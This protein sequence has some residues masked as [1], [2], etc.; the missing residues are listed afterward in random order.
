MFVRAYLRASTE[1]QNASRAKEQLVTFASERKHKVAACY[2]ENISGASLDRPELQRLL[3]DSGE[4]DVL[5][6][7]QVDRLT[8]L[9][10]SDWMR[11]KRAIDDKGVSIVALDLPTSYAAL[12]V[13][14]ESDFMR[15]ML[16]A[17]NNMLLDMLAAVARKDF[18]DRRR[19]QKQ[20]IIRAKEEGRYTGRRADTGKHEAVLKLRD[21]G[22]TLKG[23]AE[24]TGYSKATVCRVIKSAK[25]EV[26]I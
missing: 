22:H 6:L 17:I 7:E 3:D 19:R 16:K 5:L 20:G 15:S 4:G 18:E 21:A 8:R 10:E 25:E 1:D 14:E 26:N 9:T 11:L 12:D 24:V 13:R 23:I 2:I